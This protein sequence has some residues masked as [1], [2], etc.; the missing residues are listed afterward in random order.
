MCCFFVVK[1]VV[2]KSIESFDDVDA[3]QILSIWY[4]FDVVFAVSKLQ[5][6][7]LNSI[8]DIFCMFFRACA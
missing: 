7:M 6:N 1:I 4:Q 3:E 8:Y 5:L 2:A